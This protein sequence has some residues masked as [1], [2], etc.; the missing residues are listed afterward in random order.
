MKCK[1]LEKDVTIRGVTFHI[2]EISDA[3]LEALPQPRRD[4]AVACLALCVPIKPLDEPLGVVKELAE[5][6]YALSY[7]SEEQEKNS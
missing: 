4:Y 3:E 5:A 1:R 2:R 7:G 6:A